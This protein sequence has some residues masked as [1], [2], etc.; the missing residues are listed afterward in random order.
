V[1]GFR[2]T[3]SIL[4]NEESAFDGDVMEVQSAH[5]AEKK[6]PSARRDGAAPAWQRR[7]E[8]YSQHLSMRAKS[9]AA[10]K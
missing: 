5:C 4:L 1:H 9:R 10:F 7:Q 2:S 6:A 3:A 8:H